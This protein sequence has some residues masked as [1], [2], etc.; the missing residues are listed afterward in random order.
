MSDWG[1]FGGRLLPLFL[2]AV[3]CQEAGPPAQRAM[4]AAPTG[5]SAARA[6]APMPVPV[7]IPE[8]HAVAP[9]PG[10]VVRVRA[11]SH[12]GVPL[13]AAPNTRAV[14]GRLA[15]GT[16]V[17]V[18]SVDAAE[19]WFE[20]AYGSPKKRAFVVR[21]YLDL[22]AGR[23]AAVSV[24]PG[25]SLAACL[26]RL[27]RAAPRSKAR[28]ATFNVRW[29]PDGVP[30][31]KP[32]LRTDIPWLACEMALAGAEAIAV[33]EFK[34]L[35]HA[36]LAVERLRSELDQLTGGRWSAHFDD[37]P[38]QAS[39]HVGVFVDE[40]R[41]KLERTRVVSEL[42]PLGGACQGSLR[43]GFLAHVRLS[44]GLPATLLS[45]HL[46]SGTDE[47][48]YRL[49]AHSIRSLGSLVTSEHRWLV[50]GDFNTMGCATCQPVVT[51][52]EERAQLKLAA[53][54]VGLRLIEPAAGCSHYHRG[55]PGLLDGIL[56]SRS[57]A[58]GSV[59]QSGGACQALYCQK[60]EP[61]A[62]WATLSDHCPLSLELPA[63]LLGAADLEPPR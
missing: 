29:F 41:V 11:K 5:A 24:A 57:F 42:N 54:R 17:E 47:R 59:A 46:K 22:A 30:G 55:R 61:L 48:S 4:A 27:A 6:S 14:S 62:A 49:R 35:P 43:P 63:K 56:V 23:D 37:C 12:L 45:V 15:D 33:Q 25:S 50:L 3:G 8:P 18:V 26:T 28:V 36:Q 60:G 7:R 10:S 44:D 58:R 34:T 51:A 39:L 13:H 1:A 19:R 9:E 32:K 21:R 53:E 20:I 31:K 52:S 16:S 40:T 38:D 2:L